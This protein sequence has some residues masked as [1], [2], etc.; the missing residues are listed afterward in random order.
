MAA[1]QTAPVGKTEEVPF[2]GKE[3]TVYSLQR[4][5]TVCHP[6]ILLESYIDPGAGLRQLA[7]KYKSSDAV[8]D[9]LFQQPVVAAPVVCM[10]RNYG[11]DYSAMYALSSPCPCVI[12]G[13]GH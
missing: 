9:E 12:A 10:V 7:D 3:F 8:F 2:S 11:L 1:S 4:R 13:S 5:L 6:A